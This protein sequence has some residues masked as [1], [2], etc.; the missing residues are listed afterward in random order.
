LHSDKDLQ[1]LFVGGRKMHPT[2]PTWQRATIWKKMINCYI[3][4]TVW[5][6]LILM[7]LTEFCTV[8]HISSPEINTYSKIQ[9]L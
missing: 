9:I 3:S 1:V 2:N 5:L 6:I 7:I 4:A 8:M